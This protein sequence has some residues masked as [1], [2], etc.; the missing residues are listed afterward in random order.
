MVG[1]AYAVPVFD[2]R[3]DVRE[4]LE[5]DLVAWMTT[6]DADGRPR[7]SVVW[8]VVDGDVIAVY[9]RAGT[10]RTRNIEQRPAVALHLNTNEH[11]DAPIVIE[12]RAEII[13]REPTF[14]A[15]AAYFGKY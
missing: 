1:A 7:P 9:S 15:H 5:T 8:F 10:P 6:V 2:E 4:R 12:G 3:P 13:G 14:D 11:G